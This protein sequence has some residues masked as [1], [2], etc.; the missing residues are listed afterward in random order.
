MAESTIV[1]E[2]KLQAGGCEHS[3]KQKTFGHSTR[4]DHIACILNRFEKAPF[5]NGGLFLH[6]LKTE[7]REV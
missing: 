2:G 1:P 5:V 4:E 7:R 6:S 3:A